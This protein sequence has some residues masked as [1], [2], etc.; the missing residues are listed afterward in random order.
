[1]KNT[2]IN[3][4]GGIEILTFKEIKEISHKKVTW[5]L[6]NTLDNHKATIENKPYYEFLLKYGLYP[7]I[8]NFNSAV[9]WGFV[10]LHPY[11]ISIALKNGAIDFR[12]SKK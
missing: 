4:D 6:L 7:S 2:Y 12:G 9:E 10:R 8:V 11:D 3:M 5:D 1:M